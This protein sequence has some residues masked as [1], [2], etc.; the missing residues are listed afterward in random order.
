MTEEMQVSARDVSRRTLV[1]A[2]AWSVPVV[3][4]TVAS[5]AAVASEGNVASLTWTDSET[6]LLALR[7]LD[8]ATVITAQ[9]LVTVP[10]EFT[11]V[12]GGGAITDTA[13]VTIT[14]GRP[15][16]LNIALG[17]ARGFGVYS[18]DGVV[19]ATGERTVSYEQTAIT[20]VEYGFP[21]TTY[22]GLAKS[23]AVASN[24]SLV[25]PVE[26]GLAGTHTTIA[27]IDLLADFP[28]TLTVDFGAGRSYTAN[29]TISVPVG[30][31]IL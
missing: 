21:I 29:T 5:P 14:V 9:A 25:I 19:T 1:K 27:S 4:M 13:T 17:T 10:T 22:T 23:F 2:A 12:N 28:V 30:A 24:G 20:N 16:G 3:A 31:G 11:L 18:Y 8:S 6:G 26:F 7:V 15:T